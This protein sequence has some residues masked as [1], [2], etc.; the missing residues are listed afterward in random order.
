MV[1][2]VVLLIVFKAK[3]CVNVDLLHSCLRRWCNIPRGVQN[4]AAVIRSF[5]C[6]L[7]KLVPCCQLTSF[8]CSLQFRGVDFEAA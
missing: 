5:V 8:I 1:V 6:A 2:T 7:L 4:M 3:I